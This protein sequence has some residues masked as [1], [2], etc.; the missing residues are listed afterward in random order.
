MQKNNRLNKFNRSYGKGVGKPTKPGVVA[1]TGKVLEV[2][3]DSHFRIEFEEGVT[4][5]AYLGGKMKMY[6][7]RVSV[8]DTVETEGHVLGGKSRVVKRL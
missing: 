2:L 5:V 7:I 1:K 4:G 6:K 3:P 8:G